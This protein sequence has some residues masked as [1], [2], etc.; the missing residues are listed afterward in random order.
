[1]ADRGDFIVEQLTRGRSEQDEILWR[2]QAGLISAQTAA[3]MLASAALAGD[4]EHGVYRTWEPIMQAIR[5]S[6]DERQTMLVD[7]LVHMANL[8]PAEDSDGDQLEAHDMLLWG[9][10]HD[11]VQGGKITATDLC[12]HFRRSS[13]VRAGSQ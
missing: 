7:L 13:N 12:V 5:D 6:S 4:P 2:F 8:P 9:V 11:H 1:M 10:L 3:E